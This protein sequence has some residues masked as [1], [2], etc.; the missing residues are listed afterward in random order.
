MTFA[1]AGIGPG[2]D[3]AEALA[4]ANA[5]ATVDTNRATVTD[6][7]RLAL[8]ANLSDVTQNATIRTQADAI[9]ANPG[10]TT[11]A[12]AANV[13]KLAQGISLLAAHDDTTKREL[14]GLIRLVLGELD[15]VDGT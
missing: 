4:Q 3:E 10:S 6:L 2:P 5:A 12:I 9:A 13:A 1:Y 15:T 14:Q 8:A 11:P 7:A